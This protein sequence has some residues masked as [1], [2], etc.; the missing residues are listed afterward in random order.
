MAE[1]VDKCISN[2]LKKQRKNETFLIE[3]MDGWMCRNDGH[4][5]TWSGMSRQEGNE[6][7]RGG[8]SA[9][10]MFVDYVI[11]DQV[12]MTGSQR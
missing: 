4:C 6:R 9:H 1:C 7:E 12:G 11:T 5:V 3:G 2:A 8:R 10:G